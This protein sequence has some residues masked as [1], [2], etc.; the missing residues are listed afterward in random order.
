M[1]YKPME[2][3]LENIADTVDV[4]K[5]IRPIYNFKAGEEMSKKRSDSKQNNVRLKGSASAVPFSNQLLF[6]GSS[7]ATVT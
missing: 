3:I 7:K 1:A 5:I 6:A 2:S 4:E